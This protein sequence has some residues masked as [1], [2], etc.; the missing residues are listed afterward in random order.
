MYP[1]I[2]SRD[3][4]AINRDTSDIIINGEI[5]LVITRDGQRMIK[6]LCIV[7]RDED[8]G[9]IIRC[10]SDNPNQELYAPFIIHGTDIHNIFRVKG[11][12]SAMFF[13]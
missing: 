3:I 11:S 7:G 10:I 6:R 5:Y 12:I 1:T 8:S 4:I 9:D 2:R 13:G